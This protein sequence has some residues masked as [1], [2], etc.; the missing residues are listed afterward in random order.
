MRQATPQQPVYTSQRFLSSLLCGICHDP[1]TDGVLLP[2]KHRFCR[3]CVTSAHI[4][5]CPVCRGP[6]P[7]VLA[8]IEDVL[9]EQ[10]DELEVTCCNEAVCGWVGRRGDFAVH[11]AKYCTG[12][13]CVNEVDGCGWRGLRADL[14]EHL[15][16]L[17]VSSRLVG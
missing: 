9:A 7:S 2:C 17:K 6:L 8:P 3:A 5:T 14:A 15:D 11:L 16:P 13:P 1:L 12:C 10:L 4:T